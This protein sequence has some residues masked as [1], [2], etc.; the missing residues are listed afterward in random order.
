MEKIDV[1]LRIETI[2]E[3]ELRRTDDLQEIASKV[4]DDLKQN[5][6]IGISIQGSGFKYLDNVEEEDNLEALPKSI[7]VQTP[8][9]KGQVYLRGSGNKFW[10]ENSEGGV[11]LAQ[12]SK[13]IMLTKIR[14]YT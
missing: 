6:I 11:V 13:K 5:N 2:L 4:Y 10:Y 8:L 1:C 3:N 9:F 14:K 12:A 7:S